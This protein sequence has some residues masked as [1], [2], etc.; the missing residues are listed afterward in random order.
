MNL[1]SPLG[2]AELKQEFAKPI[3]LGSRFQGCM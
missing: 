1:N 2:P 3:D